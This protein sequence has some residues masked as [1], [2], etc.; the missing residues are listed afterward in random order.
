MSVG[1]LSVTVNVAPR[2]PVAAGANVTVTVQLAPD[3]KGVLQELFWEKSPG[4]VPVREM[5]LMVTVVAVSLVTVKI[6]CAD[7]PNPTDPK[8]LLEGEMT[9]VGRK[10]STLLVEV[11]PAAMSSPPLV[12]KFPS[13]I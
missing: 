10:I 12:A 4:F 5:P 7:V 8:F 6:C 11:F 1:A 13:A 3:A 9:T 2:A